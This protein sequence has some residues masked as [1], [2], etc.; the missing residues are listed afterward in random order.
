VWPRLNETQ[1]TQAWEP[2]HFDGVDVAPITC[3]KKF[4]MTV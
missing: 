2:L 1:A 4:E 3:S